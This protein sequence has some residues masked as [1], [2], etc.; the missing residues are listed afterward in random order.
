MC[1]GSAPVTVEHMSQRAHNDPE[2]R[3]FKLALTHTPTPCQLRLAGC[4]G[5]ATTPDHQPR[6]M[7]HTHVRGTGCC[8]LVPACHHCNSSDG[9]SAANRRDRDGYSW[10]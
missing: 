6:L 1:P 10:P 5:L 2:Y 7:A 4:T 8:T 3:A 9:R